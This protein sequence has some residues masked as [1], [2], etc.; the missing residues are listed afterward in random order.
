MG[1]KIV[2]S[3]LIFSRLKKGKT[4]KGEKV[5]LFDI[6]ICGKNSYSVVSV[7]ATGGL[8]KE[9]EKK[10]LFIENRPFVNVEG[11]LKTGLKM[12]KKK[13]R[14]V[15]FLIADKVDFVA[16]PRFMPCKVV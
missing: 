15:V 5:V 6:L 8:A 7:V 1:G 16:V 13:K 9:T 12:G 2:F 11:W 3:G 4:Q 14:A 10:H